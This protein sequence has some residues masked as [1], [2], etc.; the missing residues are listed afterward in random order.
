[1][2]MLEMEIE[3]GV[4]TNCLFCTQT[5]IY[6]LFYM[7]FHRVLQKFYR[8]GGHSY[9]TVEEIITQRDEVNAPKALNKHWKRSGIQVYWDSEAQ[10]HNFCLIESVLTSDDL[11]LYLPF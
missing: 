8:V 3:V 1:M 7:L 11:F 2:E 5:L 10:D 6:V 4:V 9:L